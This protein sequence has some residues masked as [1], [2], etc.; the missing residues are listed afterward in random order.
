MIITIVNRTKTLKDNEVLNAIRAIN[1][2][3]KE[4]FE[5]YWSLSATLRLEGTVGA[6]RMEDLTG[7]KA[8]K[9]KVTEIRGDAV[10]YLTDATVNGNAF[11]YHEA[12]F[13]GI[14][15]GFVFTELCSRLKENW[16]V[17]LSH[18]VLELIGD[19]Q[20]NLLVQGPHPKYPD[21]EV[22][23]WFEMCDA[24]QSQTYEIDGIEVANFVLP[25]YFTPGEQEGGRNDFLGKLDDDGSGLSSFSVSPGGYIGYYDPKTG[26]H[27]T[28]NIPNDKKAAQR[29]KIKSASKFGRGFVR[30]YGDATCSKEDS[31]LKAQS[32][33]F[34]QTINDP[35]KHIVVLAMENRSFD[36]LLGDATKVYPNLEGI[37]Q[38]KKYS[39]ISSKGI[40]YTQKENAAAKIE[41][42]IPH[43]HAYVLRQL[44][45]QTGKLMG[46]FVDAYIQSAKF[47]ENNPA[48]QQKIEQVMS[49]FP[50]SDGDS[51]QDSLP[52]LHALAREFLVCDHWFSSMPGPTWQ[53]RFFIH[54]GTCKGH[55]LMPSRKAPQDIRF[56]DQDTIYDRL[57]TANKSWRIY[58]QGI[59]QSIVMSHMWLKF[60]L[61]LFTD[62]YASMSQFYS[63]VEGDAKKFPEYVF[64]EPDYF[65]PN[66]NDQHPPSD[67]AAGD[68]LIADV[69]NAL[70]D[71]EELWKSTLLIIT[72]DEHGGFYD[73]VFPPATVA[74]DDSVNEYNFAR[75]GVRV[76]TILV[77]P[78]LD[79]GVCKTVFDHTSLLRYLCDKWGMPSLSKRMD[80]TAGIY[81]ANSFAEELKKRDEPRQDAPKKIPHRMEAPLPSETAKP[82]ALEGAREALLSFTAS[83]PDNAQGLRAASIESTNISELS[84]EALLERANQ[85]FASLEK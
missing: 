45:E 75:L 4:D 33:Q 44:G 73:H 8:R 57:N 37:P 7:A 16:T 26:Q 5:P 82:F 17:T 58:H 72:Y 15:F 64:I 18:E 70:R 59:P 28:Y 66:E 25:L 35:I 38:D 76:P 56:Y 80:E 21:K 62:S 24:V 13:R 20:G 65:E 3:I 81:R 31:Q 41:V 48:D 34:A 19:A 74:P 1:R 43:E 67:I 32:H 53:N 84:D 55:V 69:Y 23:H 61:S 22:F 50:F 39:N 6:E 71:N 9:V 46:G 27:E 30:K 52:A 79:R 68:K 2:Q 83:L 40:E 77:S 36:H 29:V 54:S 14:P 85:R 10:I 12:N 63:D 78:W 60:G 11:G 51:K 47:D 49:Y 42:D